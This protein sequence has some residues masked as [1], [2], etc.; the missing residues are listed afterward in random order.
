MVGTEEIALLYNLPWTARWNLLRGMVSL[1]SKLRLHRELT[2]YKVGT[3]EKSKTGRAE[4]TEVLC[5]VIARSWA[6]PHN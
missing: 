4:Q 3:G 1:Q 5:V 6:L 2:D